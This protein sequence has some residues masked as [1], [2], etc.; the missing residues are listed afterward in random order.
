[1]TYSNS[2][3]RRFTVVSRVD[4]V[5]WCASGT[6]N[7]GTS[8]EARTEIYMGLGARLDATTQIFILARACA[9]HGQLDLAVRMGQAAVAL[10]LRDSD[11]MKWNLHELLTNRMATAC[12]WRATLKF[13]DTKID[14]ASLLAEVSQ[15]SRRFPDCDPQL[16][17][18]KTIKLLRQMVVEDRQHAAPQDR[19]NRLQTDRDRVTDLIFE[20]R[21]QCGSQWT[22]PGSCDIFMDRRGDKSPA[23][24]LANLRAAAVPQLIDVLE[25]E[26]FTRSVEFWRDY[27]FSHYPL[28]IGDAA[29]AILEKI[30]S[31]RFDPSYGSILGVTRGAHRAAVKADARRWWAAYQDRG[32]QTVLAEIVSHGTRNSVTSAERLVERYPEAA[33]AA[34]QEGFRKASDEEIRRDLVRLA[35]RVHGDAVKAFLKNELTTS[36][37]FSVR[38]AAA[39]GLRER[40]DIDCVSMMMEEWKRDR[41]SDAPE[42]WFNGDPLI[43]FLASSGDPRTIEALGSGLPARNIDQRA[44]VAAALAG[45]GFKDVVAPIGV[46]PEASADPATRAQVERSVEAILTDELMDASE[47]AG[48]VVAR[49]KPCEDARLCDISAQIL[50]Q[51][52]PNRYQARL[53][54]SRFERDRERMRLR[55]IWSKENQ[56]SLL[57]IPERRKV[58][59]IAPERTTAALNRVSDASTITARTAALAEIERFGLPALPAVLAA[60]GATPSKAP[61]RLGL[62]AIAARLACTVRTVQASSNLGRLSAD[63]SIELQRM[64]G[65]PLTADG[66][67]DLLKHAALPLRDDMSG[68]EL[69]AYRDND[70]AGFVVALNV[71]TGYPGKA[72]AAF[73]SSAY[74]HRIVVDNGSVFGVSG[75]AGNRDD[76]DPLP[77]DSSP[78]AG[79]DINL[80]GGINKALASHPLSTVL[81]AL[82]LELRRPPARRHE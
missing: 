16:H 5:R 68:I 82:E 25:D 70:G 63:V 13:S 23:A 79:A 75:S 54:G 71:L 30:A 18:P 32:E 3:G 55:N 20:L 22:Q 24:Q 2:R 43:S 50:I 11:E 78:D 69:L 38:V 28:C 77:P 12:V 42:D 26:R 8:L 80:I 52:W 59:S 34:I 6:A 9:A 73:T 41:G 19:R 51:L 1:M 45:G 57:P 39:V 36:H 21:D 67:V 65:K 76:R 31:R 15:I 81:I 64:K 62:V 74:R 29:E 27:R 53:D 48:I 44:N 66:V 58:A 37:E 61:A 60:I 72:A 49:P 47:V 14:R 35:C 33:L 4:L 46:A 7:G 10:N 17:V 40:G 56:G